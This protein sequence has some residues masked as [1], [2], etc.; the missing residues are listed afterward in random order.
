MR[1]AIP[2]VVVTAVFAQ[3]PTGVVDS[4]QSTRLV[5]VADVARPVELRID[6]GPAPWRA[7]HGDEATK[8]EAATFR[9][10]LGGWATLHAGAELGVGDRRL[11]AGIWY[12]ALH[13]VADA[14]WSLA[15]IEPAKV[16]RAGVLGSGT[17]DVKPALLV[18]MR[19]RSGLEEQ[20]QLGVEL[21][22]GSA[23]S[24]VVLSMRWGQYS[25]TGTLTVALEKY[26]AEAPA[27]RKL[28][29][30]RTFRTASG[31][32]YEEVR[33]GVGAMP[34]AKDKVRVH[35]V[36]WLSDGKKFDSSIDRKAPTVFPLSAVIK[37]WTEGLQLM[38]PGAVFLL[39]IPPE[40]AYG[41]QG[42]GGAVPPD[43]TLVFWVELLAIE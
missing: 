16:L 14:G 39:E 11:P 26:V 32:R 2:F 36:G 5:W 3:T 7:Q 34:G 17:R 10:G 24:E 13:R 38:R 27:F 9:L 12:L 18:P 1:V 15:V 37:G 19:L 4:M 8:K 20:P 30:A 22:A 40:L 29:P 23:P 33:A 25:L 31:L 43:A 21:T 6:Y 42:A 28:D 41:K 35:Y